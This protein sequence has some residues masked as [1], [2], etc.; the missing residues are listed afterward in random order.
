MQSMGL[1]LALNRENWRTFSGADGLASLQ[2]EHIAEDAAGAL[3][4]ASWDQGVSRFDG[5]R[6]STFTR[7]DGLGGN[8][9]LAVYLDRKGRLWFGTNKGLCYYDGRTFQ[10]L[11]GAG[12]PQEVSY[13][14]EDRQGRLW[15]SGANFLGYY[16]GRRL[17]NLHLAF[18]KATGRNCT[19]CWGIA[20]DGHGDIWIG[21][22]QAL[23]RFDGVAFEL[24]HPRLEAVSDTTIFCLDQSP[25]GDLWIGCNR[26]VWRYDGRQFHALGKQF[27]LEAPLRKIRHDRSGC[28]WLCTTGQGALCYDGL[29]AIRFAAEDGLP[30]DKV[31]DVFVDG[32]N[33]IWFA[34]WGGGVC[35]TNGR[36]VQNFTRLDGLPRNEVHALLEDRHGRIWAACKSFRSNEHL[37]ELAYYDGSGFQI[38]RAGAGTMALCQD[39]KGRLWLGGSQ[40]LIAYEEGRFEDV[41][42]TAEWKNAAGWDAGVHALAVDGQGRLL[43]GHLVVEDGLTY[44]QISRLEGSHLARICR[45][46][47]GQ[48]DAKQYISSICVGR[49]NEIWFSL[50]CW[51]RAENGGGIGKWSEAEGVALYTAADGLA[52]NRVFDLAED[53]RGDLWLATYGGLSRFDGRRFHNYTT[54]DGLPNDRVWCICP[55]RQG[56]LWFGTDGGIARYDGRAFQHM[57]YLPSAAVNAIVQDCHGVLWF[58]ARNGLVRYDPKGFAATPARR[59]E[60][61]DGVVDRCEKMAATAPGQLD[62]PAMVGQSRAIRRVEAAVD[63]VAAT[64]MT[65]L[66]L[67]ETGTGKSLVARMLHDNSRRCAGPFVQV[68]CGAIP[69]GLAESEL[70]GHEKGAFTSAIKRKI[71][72]FEQAAGGTLFL[73]EV[74]DLSATSQ[75]SLLQV[76]EEGTFC[77]VGGEKTNRADVRVVAA[78]NVDMTEA[79]Q[80][81]AFRQDLYYRL[82]GFTIAVP[83]LRER[84]EDIPVLA[85]HFAAQFAR[86]LGKSVPAIEFAR[87]SLASN[88]DWP[89]NVRELAHLMHRAVLMANGPVRLDEIIENQSIGLQAEDHGPVAMDEFERRADEREKRYLTK[90]LEASQWQV[91]GKE[92]AATQLGVHPEKLRAR[93]KKYALKR[94]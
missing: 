69:D 70:F 18:Y 78:T 6:F 8:C 30:Y 34:T 86:Q 55:D 87:H 68:N 2:I 45:Q 35:A 32:D 89:G 41:P 7:A 66:I 50:G 49:Q 74:G 42:L 48:R 84:A 80:A 63:T 56:H 20:Q 65:V 25:A 75:Q 17:H 79:I 4:F 67:G 27:E 14:F 51:A 57:R 21:A 37:Q 85:R 81:R 36:T 60:R 1:T 43:L 5:E 62:R 26:D 23:V 28:T 64:D 93:M 76:L 46:Q 38:C 82:K 54:V 73:D 61:L 9:V 33:Q 39:E 10:P 77:R 72:R 88:H 29:E 16:D 47:T 19:Y 83:A 15:L 12:G 92:G 91:A 94:R 71:G 11:D 40:G 3:W 44:W 24:V 52:D 59:P 22:S 53:D 13:L 58:A 90:A 31:N